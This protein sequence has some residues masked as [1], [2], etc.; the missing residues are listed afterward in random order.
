MVARSVSN[1]R[2]LV[3]MVEKKEIFIYLCDST[4]LCQSHKILERSLKLETNR[5]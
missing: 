2:L 3:W 1:R 5:S 4:R